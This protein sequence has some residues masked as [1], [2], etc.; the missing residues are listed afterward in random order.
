MRFN[1]KKVEK[2]M[3]KTYFSPQT[4]IC[5][6]ELQTLMAGSEKFSTEKTE[7]NVEMGTEEYKGKF[8]SRQS[9]W[10]DEEEEEK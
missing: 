9:L 7:Q 1:L 10:A 6:I 8:G 5:H 2:T 4:S 3:K